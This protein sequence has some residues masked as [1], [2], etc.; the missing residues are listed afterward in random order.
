MAY[1]VWKSAISLG[2][3]LMVI[4]GKSVT[5]FIR[6]VLESVLKYR[7][8][9]ILYNFERSQVCSVEE[10]SSL[11]TRYYH[12][13][14]HYVG[15]IVYG[16]VAPYHVLDNK[17]SYHGVEAIN[18]ATADG[19]SVVLMA[20][21]LGNWE[22]AGLLLGR[23]LDARLTAVYKPLSNKA[24]DVIMQE[25]R[26][27][28]GVHLAP[29]GDVIKGIRSSK[30][31]GVYLLISDQSPAVKE[32]NIESSFLNTPTYFFA[33]PE[34]ISKKYGMKVFY[35]RIKPLGEGRYE[36]SFFPISGADITSQYA[37]LLEA[38]ICKDP[39]FWLWSHNRWK[40]N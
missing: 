35:Q 25:S 3:W 2:Y 37:A 12:Q 19:H 5:S 6:V 21:H 11:L 40:L 15:E 10:R 32:G 20:S 14:A 27:R 4:G 13:L 24:L 34:K 1:V 33:G 18:Q 22:W 30:S 16:M 9:V 23:K 38:D 36:V 7:K 17:M 39:E 26:H 29:M 8:K 28:F 31:P